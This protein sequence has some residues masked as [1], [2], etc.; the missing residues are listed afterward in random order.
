VEQIEIAKN[1]HEAYEQ[2]G[3]FAMVITTASFSEQVK[4]KAEEEDIIL[5]D[6]VKFVDWLYDK[7]P[8]LSTPTLYGLGISVSPTLCK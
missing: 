6:G 8:E 5:I 1:N 2:S 3:S 7:L 4:K